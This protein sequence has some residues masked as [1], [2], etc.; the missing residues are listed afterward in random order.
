MVGASPL[1]LGLIGVGVGARQLVPALTHHPHVRLCA[2]ADVR[3]DAVERLARDY[4]IQAFDSAEALCA[5]NELDA[6]WVVTP[7]HLHAEH[8]ILAADHGKHVI[9]SKPMAVTLDD[10]RAMNAAAARNAVVLLAGHSQSM[11]PTIRRMA[12]IVQNGELGRLGMLHTWHFT[13]WMYRPRLPDELDLARGGGPVFRQAA[14][15]VD[16]LREIAGRAVRAVRAATVDLDP[17]RPLAGAYTAY[18]EFEDGTPATIVYSGYGHF[19]MAAFLRDTDAAPRAQAQ[20]AIGGDERER[21]EALRNTPGGSNSLGLFGLTVA[22]CAD[23]DIRES[24]EGLWIYGREGRR[25]ENVIDEPR[26]TAELDE[27]YAAVRLNAAPLHDGRWGQATLEACLAIHE[28]ARTHQ[29]VLL[30]PQ[31]APA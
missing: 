18:L 28:S 20:S 12:A 23:A 22:T 6:V 17:A 25:S 24:P 8:A 31:P 14:H 10:A 15:Q 26:G 9:V 30:A 13:D 7:N 21:K 19:D 27:L 4:G 29:E 5:S 2:A 11:A 1:R 3:A 16:I